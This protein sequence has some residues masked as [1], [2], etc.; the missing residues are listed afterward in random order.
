[1]SK[2]KCLML[3]LSA[4]IILVAGAS[5]PAFGKKPIIDTCLG[6]YPGDANSTGTVT[7]GD[8]AFLVDYLCNSGAAPS[9][10]ANGDANGDCVIDS[11]DI[12]CLVENLFGSGCTLAECTCIRPTKGA[13]YDSCGFQYPGDANGSG[14]ITI[15]DISYLVD[16]LCNDGAAPYPPSNGDANGDCVIDSLDIIC[17]IEELFGSGCTIVDCT[18]INPTKGACFDSCGFQYPGDANGTG[19]ITIGDIS[20]LVDYLCYDGDA[21]NPPANG[22]ANGDCVIDSLDIICL[23]EELFGNG[24]T[25]VDCTCIEPTKGDCYDTCGAQYPGDANSTGTITIGDISY[26]VDYLCNDG[27]APNPPANGDA[28]GDCVID[29]LDIDCLIEQLYGSG[30]TIVD[31]TCINPVKGACHTS[32]RG[33]DG[34]AGDAI[35]RV[36]PNNAIPADYELVQNNPNP[37]NPITEI[38]FALPTESEVVL[39]VYSITGQKIVTLADAAYPA[40]NHIVTWDSKDTN[41]NT[42]ASGIYL[43]T[44]KAGS[45][46]ASRKMVLLK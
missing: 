43:Y 6:Q 30:C 19:D 10:L 39:E 8:I 33:L 5:G 28:N 36:Q 34:P 13:C 14:T 31:C 2:S 20:Y 3:T 26:L 40:G 15:G 22:D 46:S 21:P 45:F 44:I 16:Y 9:P 23:I 1:M 38:A 32:A 42:V 29:S 7:I 24:C 11:L 27:A 35:R 37:F 18:C 25:I 12:D 4:L 17:L 41:G